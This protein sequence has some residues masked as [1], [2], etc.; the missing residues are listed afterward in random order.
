MNTETL[1]SY[2]VLYSYSMCTVMLYIIIYIQ[3][4]LRASYIPLINV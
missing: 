4:C 1:V 2:S 3:I